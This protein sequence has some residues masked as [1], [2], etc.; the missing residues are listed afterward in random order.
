GSQS[1]TTWTLSNVS[2]SG[3]SAGSYTLYA[4]ATDANGVSSSVSSAPLAVTSVPTPAIRSFSARP[5]SV[6]AGSATTLTPSH[7]TE[8]GGTISSVT[9]YLESNGTS[10][11]QIGSDTLIG[12]GSQ[13][14]TTWTTSFST[15][16]LSP[17]TYV[18]YAVATDSS[19]VTSTTASATLTVTAATT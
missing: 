4:V 17:G 10:G 15:A 11:L 16:G 2:T 5:S 1:G 3:L 14:G 13:N 19:G 8:T 6:T 12:T 9:F 7:V 18:F